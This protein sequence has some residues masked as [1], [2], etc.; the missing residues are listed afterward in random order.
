MKITAAVTRGKSQPFTIEEL[1]LDEPREDEVLVR[2]VSAGICHTDLT[3]RDQYFPTPLPAVLG[4]EGAGVVEQVGRRVTKVQPGDHVVLTAM[5]CGTCT[6]CLRARPGNCSHLYALNFAAVRP[7]GSISLHKG[8]EPINGP[9]FE[10]SSFAT[11]ALA[12]ER[13]VV[14]VRKDAPLEL[15]GPLGCGIQTGAGAVMNALK[16]WAGSSIAVFGTG[17]VGLSAIMAARIVGCTTIIGVDVRPQRL[18]LAQEL[19]ATHVINGSEGNTLEQIRAITGDGVDFSLEAT[20]IPQIFRQAVECIRVTGVC[21][22][23]GAPP[24]DTEVT[25]DVHSIIW[26]RT[27]R[28]IVLGDSVPDIFIPQLIDLYLQGRL[29]FDKL[30]TYYKLEEI[31]TAADLSQ[32]GEVLKPVLIFP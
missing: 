22:I 31:N 24:L 7:D 18:A 2:V 26:G 14:K 29:P 4:H 20:G 30:I 13:S 17:S 21:G 15:L 28:G 3:V 23:V 27:I 5:Y 8:D 6:N 16:P 1:D 10:Q 11:Y 12:N 25:L 19:G 9:F 32:A